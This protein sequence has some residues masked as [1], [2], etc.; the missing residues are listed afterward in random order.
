MSSCNFRERKIA[1]NGRNYELIVATGRVSKF[2]RQVAVFCMYLKPKMLVADLEGLKQLIEDQVLQLKTGGADP[3]IYV[4]GDLNKRDLGPAFDNFVDIERKNHQPTRG[5]ACLDVLYSNAKMSSAVWPPL[6]TRDG[7]PSDHSCVIFQVEEMRQ[8]DFVWKHKTARKQT[9]KACNRY[10]VDLAGVD[11]ASA[12]GNSGDPTTLVENFERILSQ[13]ADEHFPIVRRR[14][15]SNE[16]PW[17]TDGVR[18]LQKKK[19]RVYKRDGKCR[20]WLTLQN[21]VD[22]LLETS[23]QQFANKAKEGGN[24]RGFY[25]AVKAMAAGTAPK[26][27]SVNDLYPG[28][29]DLEVGDNITEFY[30]GI[31]SNFTPLR[32]ARIQ[33]AP[34]R[35]VSQEEVLL[36][37][38]AAKK[39]SS[40]VQGDIPPGL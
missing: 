28:L 33:G 36:K 9:D 22:E 26:E 21:K 34:R 12:L 16:A 29:S 3:L 17:V 24:V 11:W 18:S 19:K 31:T 1:G 7:V 10:C 39:P 8:R 13:L 35:P 4:G 32:P 27:W 25:N 14:V 37:L 20:L 38:K 30:T 2:S 6:H 5:A 15:R 40:Q 23:K